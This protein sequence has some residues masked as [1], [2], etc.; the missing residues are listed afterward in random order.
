[1]GFSWK[2][3]KEVAVEIKTER[4]M[5][6]AKSG[7]NPEFKTR[8]PDWVRDAQKGDYTLLKKQ[9]KEA[10]EKVQQKAIQRRAKRAGK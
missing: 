8:H 3:A 5:T 6:Q 9:V 7:T 10:V 2:K 1:M 4:A